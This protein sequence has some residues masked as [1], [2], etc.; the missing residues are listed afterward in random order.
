MKISHNK[1]DRL[2][3]Q[4]IEWLS[5]QP[6]SEVDNI[7]IGFLDWQY[8]SSAGL[9]IDPDVIEYAGIALSRT[10][11]EG[12][13][14]LAL[15]WAQGQD[16]KIKLL[17]LAWFVCGYYLHA[18]N[19]DRTVLECFRRWLANLDACSSTYVGMIL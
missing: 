7:V 18:A 16:D 5:K 12:I 11:H 14:S 8:S 13:D 2:S 15:A 4:E 1:L 3:E 19:P 6:K 9:L 10:N 17:I